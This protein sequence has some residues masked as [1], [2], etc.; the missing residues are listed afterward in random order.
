MR[1]K[2]IQKEIEELTV[3]LLN[4]DLVLDTNSPIIQDR[5]KR[6]YLTWSGAPK[7]GLISNN[8]ATISEY[9]KIILN[10]FYNFVLKDGGVVQFGYIFEKDL[11]VKQRICFFPCP[12]DISPEEVEDIKPGED[13]VTLFQLLL[14]QEITE[15]NVHLHEQRL[16]EMIGR[17]YTR[18]P[19]RFE[20][21]SENRNI[22]HP[23]SHL[24]INKESFRLPISGPICNGHFIHLI[25]RL[26]YPDI[27]SEYPLIRGWPIS[28]QTRTILTEHSKSL[29]LESNC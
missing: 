6:E 27:W 5:N 14:E 20:F 4:N 1:I 17:F 24:H 15:I 8:F 23:S 3:F 21:D 7:T 26:F 25:F 29:Y 19:L 9:V 13:F 2:E 22:D 10:R 11:L 18:S 16:S 12:I 28:N